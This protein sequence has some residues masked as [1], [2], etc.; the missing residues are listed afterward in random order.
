MQYVVHSRKAIALTRGKPSWVGSLSGRKRRAPS[1]YGETLTYSQPGHSA[2]A[3]LARYIH[4]L[5]QALTAISA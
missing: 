3:R 1:M 5:A 2:C 4:M